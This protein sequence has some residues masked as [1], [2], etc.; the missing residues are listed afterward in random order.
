MVKKIILKNFFIHQQSS[1]KYKD[2]C[3]KFLTEIS[4]EI[5]DSVF[6]V[7]DNSIKSEYTSDNI[8]FLPGSNE[9]REFSSWE[10]GYQAVLKNKPDK[11]FNLI[12]SNETMFSHRA[13]DMQLRRAFIRSFTNAA[14]SE[15]SCICGDFDT[16]NQK[17]DFFSD[18]FNGHISTYLFLINSAAV[19]E[20]NGFLEMNSLLEEAFK[21]KYDQNN[22]V[23][24]TNFFK[25]YPEY[26][27][28]LENW[29]YKPGN[30]KKWYSHAELTEKN[31]TKQK[32]KVHSII[33]EH[34]ITSKIV[35]RG[36]SIEDI[37]LKIKRN[38]LENMTFL[39]YKLQ[40]SLKW[41]LQKYLK[42]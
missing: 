21:E 23:F 1:S 16:Y 26:L 31:Y 40:Y 5:G 30:H 28:Q 7:I 3:L 19:K 12:V 32:L 18:S 25:K 41:R 14:R 15:T 9:F 10:I 36:G 6:F 39:F 4:S 11:K 17:N 2:D 20:F 24:K 35:E 34:S 13:F 33:L 38:F 37:R 8:N 27:G 22:S 42:L 29:V